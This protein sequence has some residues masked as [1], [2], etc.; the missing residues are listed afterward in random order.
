[1]GQKPKLLEPHLKSQCPPSAEA[2]E[3]WGS[4]RNGPIRPKQPEKTR[5]MAN[6]RGLTPAR[7]EGGSELKHLHRDPL[8]DV[9]DQLDIGIVV[10]VGSP[11]DRYVVVCHFD[12]F[13]RQP[14][15]LALATPQQHHWDRPT[16]PKR[17]TPALAFRSSGVTMTTKRMALSLRNIS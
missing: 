1:M 11:T 15:I 14:H 16:H 7:A 13:C 5:E 10:V 6:E 12:V 8:G 2:P 9:H 17:T 4:Q 3:V